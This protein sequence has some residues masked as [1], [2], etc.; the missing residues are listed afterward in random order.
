MSNE[1]QTIRELIEAKLKQLSD[2]DILGPHKAS[3]VLV[4][5]SAL[6]ASVGK[7]CSD[8]KYWL[9]LKKVELLKE[10]ISAAKA[11][12]YAEAS[13]EWKQWQEAEEYQKATIEAIRAIKYYLRTAEDEKRNAQ[14]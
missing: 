11:I 6:L 1:P 14:Y 7:E 2:I 4:E 10:H 3:E 13:Q 5:L 9:S 12:I 8:R